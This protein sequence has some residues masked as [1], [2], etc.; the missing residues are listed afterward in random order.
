VEKRE[1][2]TWKKEEEIS[3]FKFEISKKGGKAPK[4]QRAGE[5]SVRPARD[6]ESSNAGWMPAPL[7]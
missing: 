6:K 5:Q 1:N 3:D 2:G 4:T 7:G